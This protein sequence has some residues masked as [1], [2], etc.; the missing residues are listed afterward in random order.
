MVARVVKGASFRLK[1]DM[2]HGF[3]SH[4]IHY[5]RC[6][7]RLLRLKSGLNNRI[8]WFDSKASCIPR[9]V[10]SNGRAVALHATGKG[11]DAPILHLLIVCGCFF[12]IER[13]FSQ[14]DHDED[15]G[16]S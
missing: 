3:E 7:L 5:K 12:L 9:G 13:C 8:I 4:T 6:L 14:D 1:C 11:I 2:L 10:S 15:D 16:F